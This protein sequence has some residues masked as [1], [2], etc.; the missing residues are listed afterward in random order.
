MSW[1]KAAHISAVLQFGLAVLQF[2]LFVLSIYFV[3]IQLRNQTEQLKK[4]R[5]QLGQQAEQMRQQTDLARVSNTQALVA[6]ASP[7]N[8]QLATNKRAARLWIRGQQDW[9]S[10]DD[11]EQEQYDSL[12]RWWFIFYENIFFQEQSYL[13]DKSI[14]SGW[15]E[16][17]ANFVAEQAVE[18]HWSKLNKQYHQ[19]FVKHMDK[20]IEEKAAALDAGK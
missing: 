5:I 20:L 11:V 12:L 19:E 16:D 3:W 4:Q 8:L 2:A 9:D 17:I 14:A 18:K 7:F 6:L 13:L 1:E 10:L 15:K